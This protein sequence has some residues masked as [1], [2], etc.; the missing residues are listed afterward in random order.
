MAQENNLT[1]WFDVANALYGDLFLGDEQAVQEIAD[2]LEAIREDIICDTIPQVSDLESAKRIHGQLL[3]KI[4][5]MQQRRNKHLAQLKNSEHRPRTYRQ[6]NQTVDGNVDTTKRPNVD[7]LTAIQ[8]RI[9]EY[10]RIRAEV[11]SFET[12]LGEPG[13]VD[14]T[15]A[16]LAELFEQDRLEDE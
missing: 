14:A 6:N 9:G 5:V 11:L 13:V 16:Q 4:N 8:Q 2:R 1:N 7:I 12:R 10:Q 15:N 3:Y